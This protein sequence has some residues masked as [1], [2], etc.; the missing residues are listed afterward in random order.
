MAGYKPSLKD[1]TVSITGMGMMY[2]IGSIVP[3]KDSTDERETKLMRLDPAGHKP[4]Q[5]YVCN[6]GC[7]YPAGQPG[8]RAGELTQRGR[9]EGGKLI[10]VD[11]SK[12]ADSGPELES[13]KL[14]LDV[15]PADQVD[16]KTWPGGAAYWFEPNRSDPFFAFLCQAARQTDVALIGVMRNRGVDKLY[17]LVPFQDGVALQEVLRPQDVREF[18]AAKATVSD[19]ERD[20]GNQLMEALR[21][22]FDPAEYA[23]EQVAALRQAIAE[24]AAAGGGAPAPAAPA[25]GKKAPK[26][27]ASFADQLEASLAQATAKKGKKAS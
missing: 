8:F 2:T 12:V 14:E 17:R 13:G 4:E 1:V 6:D 11:T 24:A 19:K 25:K 18:T 21:E 3:I 7:Q 16:T 5:Y 20:M 15:R 23:S 27:E 22:D 26:V 10:V 9:M